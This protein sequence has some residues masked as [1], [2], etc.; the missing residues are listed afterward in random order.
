MMESWKLP[1]SLDVGGKEY[2]IRTDFRAIIDI[3]IAMNDPDILEECNTEDEERQE[4]ILTM[5]QILYVDFEN[6]PVSDWQEA[7]DK[8]VEFIDMG[9]KDDG[10]K[11]P[12]T[13]DWEQDAPL[14]VPSINR[15]IGKEIREVK[16]MHWWTF[17]GAYMEIGESLFS[18]VVDIRQ[19][20]AKGKKLEKWER[21]FYRE[22]KALI[23]LKKKYS[24]AEK[25]EQ[26]ELK[27]IL[28]EVLG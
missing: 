25:A 19:K 18:H 12:H 9:I 20:K 4:K 27:A 23:D 28:D 11:R 3:L 7:A 5:L 15:V 1:T 2:K 10:Q 14:I 24:A 6:I 8:A 26:E 16:Y 17:L 13:M 22:N 21:E